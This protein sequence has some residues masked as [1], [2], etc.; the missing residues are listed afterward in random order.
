MEFLD[1]YLGAVRANL[2]QSQADDIVAEIADDLQSQADERESYLH[3]A[4]TSDESVELLKAYGHPRVVAGRYASA[5]YLIGPALLPFYW[6]SLKVVLVVMI[7]LELVGSFIRAFALNDPSAFSQG[8]GYMWNSAFVVVGIITV[9]FALIERVPSSVSPLDRIGVTRWNPRALPAV[10]AEQV[11]RVTSFFDTLANGFFAILLLDYKALVPNLAYHPT[12]AWYP[13]YVTLIVSASALAFSGIVTFVSPHFAAL[14]RSIMIAA[15]ALVILGATMTLQAGA[16]VTPQQPALNQ[17]CIGGLL[18]AIAIA[19]MTAAFNA[20]K[21]ARV[22][23]N[24]V[25]V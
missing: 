23:A 8:L 3:R 24:A 11:P 16:L 21:L 6:Y 19:A 13:F 15:N 9:I 10:G 4:L 18:V 2:P 14:R 12:G 22:R 25:T 1:R 5:Q 17:L 20:W 7:A